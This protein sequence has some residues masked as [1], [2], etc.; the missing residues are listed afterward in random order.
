VTV[1]DKR[2]TIPATCYRDLVSRAPT[3]AASTLAP[4]FRHA[5]TLGLAREQLLASLG[6]RAL[7]AD[8]VGYDVVTALWNRAAELTG[9]DAFG[10]HAAETLPPGLFDVVEYAALSAANLGEALAQMCRYQRLVTDVARYTLEGDTLRLS[11]ELGETVLTPSRHASEYLLGAV[12]VKAR[13]ATGL[14]RPVRAAHF[15]HDAPVNSDEQRRCFACPLRFT[16]AEELIV[17]DAAALEARL[18]RSDPGLRAVLDR[19]AQALLAELPDDA[20]V[21][22]RV[23]RW[24]VGNL[25]TATIGAAAAQLGLSE[26]SLQRRLREEGTAFEALLDQARK[27]EAQRLLAED[28]LAVGEIAFLLG[29]S[30]ASAFHRAFKRWTSATPAAFRKR[31]S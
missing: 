21:K 28:R 26:R 16:A 8:R 13:Q 17:L 6:K 22:T 9:D 12:V 10:V 20:Q 27:R 7:P 3:V 23:S 19:H 30:E 1:A 2:L 14:A 31:R 18:V 5:A 24:L 15:R 11:Y 25:A 4:L 29:F